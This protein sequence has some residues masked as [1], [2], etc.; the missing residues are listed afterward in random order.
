VAAEDVT[1]LA[2]ERAYRRRRTFDRR[3]GEE[4]AWLFGIARNAALDELRRRRRIAALVTDPEDV[5]GAGP[6]D[7]ADIALRRTAVRSALAA[8]P[9][10]DRELIALKF[11]AGLSNAEV[12]RVLGVSESNAGTMLHRTIEKLRKACDETA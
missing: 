12:A 6:E 9:A 4:R 2:F 3:R 8:L 5:V 10:R 11:H 7:G 1:A